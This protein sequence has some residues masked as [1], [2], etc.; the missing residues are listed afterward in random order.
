MGFLSGSVTFQ[1]YRVTEDPTGGFGESHLET[2]KKHVIGK[3]P[4]NIY[5]NPDVG[6]SGGAHLLDTEFNFEK[7]IIGE[8]M[9]FGVRIDSCQ[10]PS[11]I[12]R[13]WMHQELASFLNENPGGKASKAQRN[14]AKEAVEDRCAQEAEKGNFKKLAEVSVL[15]DAVSDTI[16]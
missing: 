1:R 6:F 8:A 13:A 11:P 10:I 15:W 2:L 3:S 5:E 16:F 7:N 14:E 4:G 9:H 12:K